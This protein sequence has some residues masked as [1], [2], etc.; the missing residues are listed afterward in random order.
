MAGIGLGL[1]GFVVMMFWLISRPPRSPLRP[2]AI[3]LLLASIPSTLFL[4]SDEGYVLLLAVIFTFPW[5]FLFVILTTFLEVNFGNLAA[6]VGAGLNA[7]VFY[8][9]GRTAYWWAES[10]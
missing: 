6:F 1:V 5:S 7:I 10:V 8:V 2:A 9:V 3:Y 4:L